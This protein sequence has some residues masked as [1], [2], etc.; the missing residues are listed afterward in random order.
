MNGFRLGFAKFLSLLVFLALIIS[1]AA[2]YVAYHSL[3]NR[4]DTANA[5]IEALGLKSS[6]A[7]SAS[8]SAT[9][10]KGTISGN[11]GF[12]A[13]TAPAQSVCAVSSTDATAKYCIDHPAGNALGYQLAVPAGS[14]TVYASL[15]APQG[16]YKTT[17]KA[18]YDKFVTCG[19]ASNCAMGLHG[20][21]E[22]VTVA[23][24]GTVTGVDPTDWYALGI[25][26]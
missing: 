24:G 15:K 8:P 12:P 23:A 14:Y 1:N 5:K 7:A 19:A 9:T 6:P 18:Y 22:V 10:A 21:N 3:E 26:Q 4:L 17:Y 2:W 25:T 20:Q 11:V 16:D 13:G